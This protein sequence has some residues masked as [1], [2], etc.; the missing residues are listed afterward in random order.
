VNTA[1]QT[2]LTHL[3]KQGNYACLLFVDYSS[4]FNT[5]LPHGHVRK[6]LNLGLPH[7]TCL[8]IKDFLSEH[9]QR[10]RIGPPHSA[11]VPLKAAC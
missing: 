4:A 8:W 7:V 5:I 1:L 2:A 3:E 6:L 9:P 10:V 11:P